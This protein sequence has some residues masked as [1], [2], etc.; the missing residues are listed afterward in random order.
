MR[1]TGS[2]QVLGNKEWG[3]KSWVVTTVMAESFGNVILIWFPCFFL[4]SLNFLSESLPCCPW[5]LR[6]AW[7][8]LAAPWI[9]T[10]PEDDTW[11]VP[12]KLSQGD[13]G[14]GSFKAPQVITLHGGRVRHLCLGGFNI[15][16]KIGHPIGAMK[17]WTW[18]QDSAVL[19]QGLGILDH[20]IVITHLAGNCRSFQKEQI[21]SAGARRRLTWSCCPECAVQ[22]LLLGSDRALFGQT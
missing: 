14:S 9:I 1:G 5:F 7:S 22:A 18:I 11:R 20:V 4:W 19:Q 3:C 13:Q 21:C 12:C 16:G 2:Q 6:K 8:L 15:S 17:T 10:L